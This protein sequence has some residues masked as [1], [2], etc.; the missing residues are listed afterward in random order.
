M[1]IREIHLQELV[2]ALLVVVGI[3][4]NLK[5]DRVTK[6]VLLGFEGIPLTSRF[7]GTRGCVFSKGLFGAVSEQD[8]LPSSVGLE[9]QARLDG[10]RMYSRARSSNNAQDSL[11]FKSRSLPPADWLMVRLMTG[12]YGYKKFRLGARRRCLMR[13]LFYSKSLKRV[14]ASDRDSP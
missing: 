9:F 12:S 5:L 4:S 7:I 8:E 3:D 13:V 6:I 1:Q 10:G 11:A 14:H 2:R